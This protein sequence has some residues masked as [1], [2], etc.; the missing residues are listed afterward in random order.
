M[1]AVGGSAECQAFMLF[2]GT[3]DSFPGPRDSPA[4]ALIS[5]VRNEPPISIQFPTNEKVELA[6]PFLRQPFPIHKRREV[7]T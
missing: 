2:G 4:L 7:T 6:N 5:A 1:L 3:V